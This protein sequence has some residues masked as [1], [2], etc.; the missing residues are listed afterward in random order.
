MVI[1]LSEIFSISFLSHFAKHDLNIFR[2]SFLAPTTPKMN[3]VAQFM[4][5]KKIQIIEE[6][7]RQSERRKRTMPSVT[8]R[9]FYRIGLSQPN[10]SPHSRSLM[11]MELSPPQ[12]ERTT[13]GR[14]RV[15]GRHSIK[16][17]RQNG[18]MKL[19]NYRQKVKTIE[20]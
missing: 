2:V 12:K 16:T 15:T 10:V 9:C 14:S 1:N 6:T 3:M 20:K 17:S 18:K 5:R 8:R 4:S 19:K 13:L 7:K 11:R